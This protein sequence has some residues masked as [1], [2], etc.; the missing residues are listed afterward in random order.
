MQFVELFGISKK[1][2]RNKAVAEATLSIRKGEFLSLLGP[3]G[4]G[5]T[6]LLRCITGLTRPDRGSIVLGGREVFDADA[7]VDLPAEKRELGMVFQSY[8][9]WPHMRVADNIGYPLRL[10]GASRSEIEARTGELLLLADIE[11]IADRFPHE[12]SGGQQQRVALCRALAPN[13]KLLLMDEPLSNLDAKLRERIRFEIKRIQK[14]T[15]IT[16]LYVTHDQTEALS[17]SDRIVVMRDGEIKQVGA[18]EEIYSEPEDDFVADFVGDGNIL[19]AVLSADGELRLRGAEGLGPIV[20]EIPPDIPP[21]LSPGASL[22]LVARPENIL[23]STGTAEGRGLRAR[24]SQALY[25]GRERELLLVCGTHSI[26]ALVDAKLD[27]KVEDETTLVFR[28]VIIM[29]GR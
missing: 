28:H 15:G 29:K 5:K 19:P 16:I 9:L 6:T 3:S 12:L 10:R 11:A 25:R 26:R 2:G 4:C 23:V 17:M 24:I 21:G 27:V 14:S 8:A 7:G 20:A 22:T 18:P 13:P 1:F